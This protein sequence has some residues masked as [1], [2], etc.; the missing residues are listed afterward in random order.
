[1]AG[2]LILV[3]APGSLVSVIF[4]VRKFSGFLLSGLYIIIFISVP[5]WLGRA[6][7]CDFRVVHF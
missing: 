2:G 7:T 1:M 3:A 5:V 4:D 6:S